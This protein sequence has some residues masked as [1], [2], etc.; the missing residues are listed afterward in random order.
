MALDN[1][2]EQLM[3]LKTLFESTG[4]LHEA[5]V[6]QLEGWA[7]V[8]Y[9]AKSVELRLDIPSK[10]CEFHLKL[11]PKSKVKSMAKKRAWMLSGIKWL[12]GEQWT[13]KVYNGKKAL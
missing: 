3:L 6:L 7:K 2:V 9:P 10:V 13:I 8:A 4:A 5:Q 1:A 12:L 11:K